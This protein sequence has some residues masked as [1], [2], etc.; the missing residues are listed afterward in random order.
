[1]E[2][3]PIILVLSSN[4]CAQAAYDQRPDLGDAFEVPIDM[5][6][7]ERVM[8]GGLRDEEVG[9]G[10]PMPHPVVTRE[11]RLKPK[12]PHQEV[13]WCVDGR[14]TPVELGL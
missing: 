6:Y 10:R 3:P 7:P 1:M 11:I 5:Q 12:R 2:K 4:R 8:H 14:E 9:Y 13:G